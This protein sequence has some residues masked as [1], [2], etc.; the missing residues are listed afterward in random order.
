MSEI[1]RPTTWIY[2]Q[3]TQI[4][5]GKLGVHWTSLNLVSTFKNNTIQNWNSNIYIYFD[6]EFI[7][8][9]TRTGFKGGN[10]RNKR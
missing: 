2:R 8:I 1:K 5:D 7:S 10:K 3:I 9:N 4:Y 6:T